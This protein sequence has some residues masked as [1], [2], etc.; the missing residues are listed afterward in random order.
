MATGDCALCHKRP[1]R[2]L[3]TSRVGH[4]RTLP[5]LQSP[6]CRTKYGIQAITP[7]VAGR[8]G[9]GN[10]SRVHVPA[11]LDICVL[12]FALA[13]PA[14]PPAGQRVSH[15][16]SVHLVRGVVQGAHLSIVIE[17]AVD[18]STVPWLPKRWE[19]RD[20][21]V[22]IIHVGVH[23]VNLT[24]RAIGDMRG[25][26]CAISPSGHRGGVVGRAESDV[27]AFPIREER[28]GLRGQDVC[29]LVQIKSR[30]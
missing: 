2:M 30:I 16:H 1:S 29:G 13:P 10:R 25:V 5:H 11:A 21:L 9:I 17:A 4:S 18:E 24:S 22:E 12:A 8:I 19:T 14:P 27:V 20:D 26:V 15:G 7:I 28:D 23:V 3:R 6:A